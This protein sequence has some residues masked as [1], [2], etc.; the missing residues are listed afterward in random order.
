MEFYLELIFKNDQ[1]FQNLI[2]NKRMAVFKI[3]VLL[4]INYILES[5]S[6]INYLKYII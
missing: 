3:Y 6:A 5:F 1:C 2:K 4:K